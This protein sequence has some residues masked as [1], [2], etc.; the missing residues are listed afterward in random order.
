[1]QPL[2]TVLAMHFQE[3]LFQLAAVKMHQHNN[4]DYNCGDNE[5]PHKRFSHE[6][7]PPRA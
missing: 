3:H 7:M 1:M 4:D 5:Y 6:V 2:S